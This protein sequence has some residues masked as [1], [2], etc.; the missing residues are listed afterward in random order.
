MAQ[1]LYIKA[2][3]KPDADSITFQLS[4]AFVEAYQKNHPGDEIVTLD[5]YREGVRFLSGSDLRDMFSGKD[6]DVRQYATQFAR[7]D[8]YIF[9]APLWNLSIPAI[10]KA[11]IDYITFAGITFKYTA[12]GPVGLLAGQNKKAAYLVARGG[13][14]GAKPMADFEMGERYL[15]TIMGFLGVTDFQTVACE[16]TNVLQGDALRAAV[17]EA[18]GSAV[19]AANAF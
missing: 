4:E 15:R 16:L 9:A 17:D 18:V 10:L 11:Y 7:A 1:L 13:S 14:Y 2:N 8:K 3:P 6:F 5:L 12:T 19:N